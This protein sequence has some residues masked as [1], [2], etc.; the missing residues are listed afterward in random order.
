[1]KGMY[2]NIVLN[3]PHSGSNGLPAGWENTDGLTKSVNR[4]TDWHTDYIFT[5]QHP[6]VQAVIAQQSRFVLD[7]ERLLDDPLESIGQGII[8]TQ[9]NGN[10]RTVSP[11]EHEH[12]MQQYN[13]HIEKLRSKI[14][15]HTLLIDCHSFPSDMEDVDICIGFNEDWSKP[16]VSLINFVQDYFEGNG[17]SVGIN[18]PFSNS[19]SPETQFTY[20]SFMI[21]LNKRIYLNESDCTCNENADRI[22][23]I[24][25]HLYSLILNGNI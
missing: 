2:D 17:L 24:I 23:E 20:H 1:M 8:Y 11:E 22:K 10:K 6:D 3:I 21:E 15:E 4:W 12:L 16:P 7:V 13:L 9:F 14:N 18:S 19:I 5:C 25:N